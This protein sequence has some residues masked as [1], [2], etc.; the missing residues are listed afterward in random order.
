[1][2]IALQGFEIDA[3]TLTPLLEEAK[4][5]LEVVADLF[6]RTA[7][8][9]PAFVLAKVSEEPASFRKGAMFTPAVAVV[10]DALDEECL[11]HARVAARSGR[12]SSELIC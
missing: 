6:G 8:W 7:V 2:R 12:V 5:L 3:L 11:V 9:M 1:M 10:E 4:A